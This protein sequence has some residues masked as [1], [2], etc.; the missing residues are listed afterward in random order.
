MTASDL[1]PPRTGSHSARSRT[2]SSC[3]RDPIMVVR[4]A[5]MG[6]AHGPTYFT[7]YH[8]AAVHLARSTACNQ[9]QRGIATVML[10]NRPT[11]IDAGGSGAAGV[12]SGPGARSRQR[13]SSAGRYDTCMYIIQIERN[14]HILYSIL[15]SFIVTKQR[16]YQ[17]IPT[18]I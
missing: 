18:I 5:C 7:T 3:P 16:L 12:W 11:D 2:P 8:S 4:Y 1:H 17:N 13:P 10:P 15:I 9:S 6:C 14:L